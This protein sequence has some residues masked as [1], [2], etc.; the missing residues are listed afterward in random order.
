MRRETTTSRAATR[1]APSRS[2]SLLFGALYGMAGGLALALVVLSGLWPQTLPAEW[3]AM[4]LAFHGALTGIGAL[5]G[6]VVSFARE[7]K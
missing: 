7:E 2:V 3:A 1:P 4:P 5:L 6:A